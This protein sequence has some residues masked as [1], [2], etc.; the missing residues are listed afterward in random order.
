MKQVLAMSI[1]HTSNMT[2]QA[3]SKPSLILSNC[4]KNNNADE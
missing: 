4:L 2:S 3:L 1:Q